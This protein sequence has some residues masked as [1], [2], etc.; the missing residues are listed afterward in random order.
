MRTIRI[1]SG[2]GYSGDRIEPAVELVEKGDIQYLIFECLAER[3]I[4]IAQQAKMKDPNA[5]YDGLLAQRMEAV[6]LGCKEKGIKIITNMG[7]ANPIAGAQKIKEIAQQLGISGLKI[8]AVTGDDVVDVVRGGEYTI[9]ET[10][11]KLSTIKDNIVSANAYLGTRPIVE[12]LR[13]DA[14]VIITGRVADPA[15]FMAPLLYEFNWSEE[16]WDIMGQGTVIGHLLECAGQITGGYFADPGYKDVQGLA[17]LGFPIAQVQEDGTFVITKVPG[18]GGNVTLATCKEQLLYEIHNPAAYITPDVVA[19]FTGVAFTQVG[20]NEIQVT[21]G[22]GQPK[23]ESLK[24]SIGY[25]DSYMG[26]GQIS[27]AGPGAVNRGKLALEIVEERLKLIGVLYQELKLDLI[28]I[29]SLHGSNLSKTDHEPYEVRARVTGRTQNMKEAVRI[30]NE[31]E[32]LYTNGPAGGGGATKS[33]K[34]VVAMVSALVPRSL[35]NY[36]L[37][38]EVI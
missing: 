26:E 15:L 9:L 1:G 7:A 12:A 11:E 34:Q 37:H 19:D 23:T 3:T 17:R 5:G 6:L 4:A 8:A 25:V 2:A 29:D 10:G 13:N 20:E 35:I 21:G 31:V 32:T 33:A 28:G 14:D 27:Y 30:G 36:K 22:K 16:N 24:V 18:S 38:Y